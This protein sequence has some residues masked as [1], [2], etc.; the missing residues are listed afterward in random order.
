MPQLQSFHEVRF[1]A[2]IA[3][4]AAI[5][6]QRMTEIITLG[7]GREQ[8]NARWE[9]SRRRYNAGYGVK[10]LEDLAEVIA[11]FEAR[12]GRLF[13]FRFRDPIDHKSCGLAVPV[14]ATDQIIGTGDGSTSEFQLAKTYGTGEWAWTR[15]IRKPV[16]GTVKIAV[17]GLLMGEGQDYDVDDTRGRV[18]FRSG[19]IP[20]PGEPVRAGFEFDVPVRF[21]TDEITVNLSN[22]IAGDIA[23]IPLIEVL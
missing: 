21:D 23:A 20:P 10:T 17:D 9:S 22:Y 3:L 8:R 18:S 4:G 14:S 15:P 6:P 16:A 13:G 2:G 11:F 5:G 1:P 7:S 12:R 19:S